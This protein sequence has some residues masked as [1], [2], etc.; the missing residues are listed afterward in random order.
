MIRT[1]WVASLVAGIW[2]VPRDTASETFLAPVELNPVNR[3]RRELG[4]TEAPS[5]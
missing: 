5:A 4:T 1:R 3:F 2:G